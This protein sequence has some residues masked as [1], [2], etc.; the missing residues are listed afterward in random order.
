MIPQIDWGIETHDVKPS[1]P[2]SNRRKLWHGTKPFCISGNPKLS[3][4]KALV[5]Q[6]EIPPLEVS[7][8]RPKNNK[9]YLFTLLFGKGKN[10]R[11]DSFN[12]VKPGCVGARSPRVQ[13]TPQP[14][15]N[16][17]KSKKNL[18]PSKRR[19]VK[20]C[21]GRGRP[22]WC[23][24]GSWSRSTRSPSRGS[25]P[26]LAPRPRCP[27]PRRTSRTP[28]SSASPRARTSTTGLSK[29]RQVHP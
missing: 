24:A 15:S 14:G 22:G 4:F 8:N 23:T 28:G 11:V 5:S 26:C 19:G 13:R 25:S 16:L 10:S 27:W 6:E 17:Q 12:S 7:R 1:E 9:K 18:A 2:F 20:V 29:K 21:A 3:S